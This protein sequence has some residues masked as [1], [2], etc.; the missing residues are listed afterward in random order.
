MHCREIYPKRNSFLKEFEP[1][2]TEIY[3]YH[4]ENIGHKFYEDLVFSNLMEILN[5][6]STN[7]FLELKE[8][9]NAGDDKKSVMYK[10]RTTKQRMIICLF[11]LIRNNISIENGIRRYSLDTE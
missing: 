4:I 9:I 7:I 5:K 2:F 10:G 1:L 3:G 8:V 6:I 11:S